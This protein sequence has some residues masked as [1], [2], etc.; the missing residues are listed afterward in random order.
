MHPLLEK[1]LISTKDA[2]VYSGYTPD[3][4]SRLCRSGKI[5]S[6]RVGRAWL[7]EKESL[8][9]FIKEQGERKNE[10]AE[11]LA[12]EREAEY[13]SARSL[14]TRVMRVAAPPVIASVDKLGSRVVV[15]A[16]VKTHALAVVVAV[17]AV[18]GGALFA[19][20]D[21]FD[22]ALGSVSDV[23]AQTAVGARYIAN[24]IALRVGE[25]SHTVSNVIAAHRAP[26]ALREASGVALPDPFALIARDAANRYA[27][28][29]DTSGA[30]LSLFNLPHAQ[31]AEPDASLAYDSFVND[32]LSA[33][34]GM[35]AHPF[36][37]MSNV[38][39][40]V[41]AMPSDAMQAAQGTAAGAGDAYLG[42][43]RASGSALLSFGVSARDGLTHAPGALYGGTLA[44]G[45][46]VTGL[47]HGILSAYEGG[48]Y[49]YAD[50]APRIV[51]SAANGAYG[52]GDTLARLTAAALPAVER[53]YVGSAY[54]IAAA[55]PATLNASVRA[56]IAL[57]SSVI[58][59]SD[60]VFAF[61]ERAVYA[62]GNAAYEAAAV[63]GNLPAIAS[64]TSALALASGEDAFLGAEGTLALD[65]SKASDSAHASVT[66]AV[67]PVAAQLALAGT[68]AGA[69]VTAVLPPSVTAAGEE[70]ALFT[71][72]TINS[73]FNHATDA[74]AVLFGP[75]PTYVVPHIPAPS[76][77]AQLAAS[78]TPSAPSRVM[79]V[80]S[81]PTY[82][83]IVEGVTQ[84]FV[85]TSLANLRANILGTVAGMIQPVS[86]QVATNVT[87]VQQVN[88]IQDLSNLILRNPD[89]SGG[90]FDGGDVTH[91][92]TV[93]GTNGNFDN[94]IAGATAL[95]T[96][97]VTGDL[98]VSGTIT[99]AI[100]GAT[101]HISAPYFVAT[102]TTATST[103]AGSFAIDTNGFVY[104]TSTRNVGIGVLSPAAL[105][106]IRNS[107]STQP[108]FI[109]KNDQ[110]AEVY[111][112]TNAGFV[113]IGSS[114]PSYALSVEGSS[115]LGTNAIAGYFTATTSTATSTFAGSF[116]V[117]TSSPYGNG[118]LTV[119]TSSPLL[120][121][122]GNTGRL[123][124]G[125]STPAVTFDIFAT[126]AMRLPV[127]TSAQR[128]SVGD[129][130][131]VRYNTSTHQFEGYGDNAVW[132][133]LGGV[134]DANQDTKIT[135]DTNNT[136]EDYLR[137]FNDG[138]QTAT[139]TN[140]GLVGIASTSPFAQLG[141]QLMP[142]ASTTMAFA[143]GSST[144]AYATSTLFSIDN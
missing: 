124:F 13:R 134:I 72:D 126:D 40:S 23:L 4:I 97:T 144:S 115:S 62:L 94:L 50:A 56:E 138:T 82:Q 93:Q 26:L 132:Q 5:S 123:G 143:I 54:G 74:L 35:T 51:A 89:I 88:M 117:G 128:P 130:G 43:L 1:N 135:A 87:T 20:A 7:V 76:H 95:A 100:I 24:D 120:Y 96:T 37:S 142:Y 31:T 92:G 11:S 104:A 129:V 91:A 58:R 99:P 80:S 108:I 38:A 16:W 63:G 113:G 65:L 131:Y 75:S 69:A 86:N 15:P 28:R 102:S 64:R 84:D 8:D 19:R 68:S 46:F 34:S 33:A 59:A 116:A 3:Y 61:H 78:T 14:P 79:A 6:V 17:A 42:L 29:G 140:H 60:A 105:L 110:G 109:A 2:S 70:A 127:G 106:D 27:T 10:R 55:I 66:A 98:T 71:Y 36:T 118:L 83:T 45:N 9:A 107:T 73:L 81:Y 57:G 25:E 41:A 12:Q 21:V 90:T 48:V 47:S 103:F 112:I 30:S 52:T 49:A 111:R 114:T 136:N 133:G 141:I 18:S 67:A 22:A 32:V 77:P 85:N 122:D 39:A 44:V 119:G 125:T 121:V 137:F 139:F 101:G 53:T